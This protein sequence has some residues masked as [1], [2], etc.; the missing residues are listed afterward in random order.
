MGVPQS[1]DVGM[2]LE[3]YRRAIK[4]YKVIR[5]AVHGDIWITQLEA[6][7]IDSE[8]FQRLRRIRQLGP[9]HMLYPCATHTRF[10]HSLGTLHI[11]QRIIN[12]INNNYE[13]SKTASHIQYSDKF[14]DAEDIFLA[15]LVALLHDLAQVSFGHTLEDEGGVLTRKQW[16]DHNRRNF[17][18]KEIRPL[19]KDYLIKEGISMSDVDALLDELEHI[20]IAEEE[21]EDAIAALE[22]PYI[23]DIVG[24]TI[25]A[26]LLDYVKRDAYFTGLSIVYD[27]RLISY[28]VIKEF[29]N[30]FRAAILLERKP[31]IVRK[32][33]L[34]YC[35][36]LLKHRYALA[37]KVYYHRVKAIL[38]AMVIKCVDRALRANLIKED[39]IWLLGDD[40]LL[41]SITRRANENISGDAES[42]AIIAKDILRRR[43]YKIVYSNYEPTPSFQSYVKEFKDKDARYQLE[44]KLAEIFSMDGLYTISQGG[45]VVYVP[46]VQEVRKEASTKM[47]VDH[48]PERI[49]ELQVL[50]RDHFPHYYQQI[51]AINDSYRYLWQFLVLLRTED[52]NN[53]L[54]VGICVDDIKAV[55]TGLLEGKPANIVNL[56]AR[57]IEKRY[58]KNPSG[59]SRK[60]AE[61]IAVSFKHPRNYDIKQID[62]V[63]RA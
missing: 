62:N 60:R 52:Y 1:E 9:T 32:D 24:N 23:A 30:K 34:S 47:F 7:I 40:I 16:L 22:R 54:D 45:F 13:Y 51:E 4:P 61:Q 27:E 29:K 57:L 55:V 31:N 21:G 58:G 8:I 48:F 18:L 42:A 17:L 26:D 25:C 35:I 20:L 43:L 12:A 39:D 3:V 19:I 53:L 2:N 33:I 56:R 49:M 37:E 14:M 28:F 10:E 50:T 5:D 36:D 59:A 15:R 6:Q 11:T 63:L 44:N 46:R 41:W 38:S